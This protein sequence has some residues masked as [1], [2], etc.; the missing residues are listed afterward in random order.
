[1]SIQ[2]LLNQF[3]GSGQADQ[4]TETGKPGKVNAIEKLTNN[5]PGGLAGGAAAGSIMALMM[6]NKKA[7]KFAGSAAKY[8]GAAMLGGL[9]YKTYKSWQQGSDGANTVPAKGTNHWLP[10][11]TEMAANDTQSPDFELRLIKTMI[12]AARADGHIDADEQQRIMKAVGE[13]NAT[14]EVRGMVFD[15][16][17]EEISVDDIA[18]GVVDMTQKSELYLVSCLVIDPDHPAEKAHLEALAKA[19]EL[20]DSLAEQIR[21]QAGETLS[22]AA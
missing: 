19:L 13:M 8:G 20:P 6:S 10:D 17:N 5:L 16:L 9:A 1:M 22:E 18:Q 11:A 15:L 12:A 21:W 2:N 7:R 14:T 3:L 4:V